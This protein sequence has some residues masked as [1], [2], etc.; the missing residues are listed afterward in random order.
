MKR[1]QFLLGTLQELVASKTFALLFSRAF[2]L[3][4]VVPFLSVKI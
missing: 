3:D 4:I 1:E 2:V